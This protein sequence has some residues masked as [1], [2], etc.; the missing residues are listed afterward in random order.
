LSKFYNETFQ[1]E[2]SLIFR[3]KDFT[4]INRDVLLDIITKKNHFLNPIEIWDKLMEWAID[5]SNELPSDVTKWT[6]VN[7]TMFK[8]LIQPFLSHINFQ[9][10]SRVD[11]F[12]KIKPFK[13]V[14]DDKFYIKILEHYSFNNIH[15][16]LTDSAPFVYRPISPPSS[17]LMPSNSNR[18]NF[19]PQFRVIPPII[20][21]Q[22]SQNFPPTFPRTRHPSHRVSR[23]NR[24]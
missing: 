2:P 10:I 7:V 24:F 14:F 11:F 1:N 3:A 23:P 12:Q 18:N 22:I 13:N 19:R 20:P 15:N 16:D 5:Q 8:N 4:T 9:E 17:P 6:D 21:Q